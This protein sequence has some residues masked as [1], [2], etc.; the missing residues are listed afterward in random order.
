MS[1]SLKS[2]NDAF[3]N[4]SSRDKGLTAGHKQQL[5]EL[6]NIVDAI[7]AEGTFVAELTKWVGNTPGLDIR[8]ADDK[9][10]SKTVSFLIA[11]GFD[12]F[13]GSPAITLSQTAAR[14]VVGKEKGYTLPYDN[15]QFLEAL[16]KAVA[17]RRA[18]VDLASQALGYV[19]SG[20]A[21]AA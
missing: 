13:A 16:G 15:D 2:F 10:D 20:K 21:P 17:E 19:R 3:N 4:A 6:K 18:N 8:R 5:D 11:F 12:A 7:N 9:D 1:I 14:T